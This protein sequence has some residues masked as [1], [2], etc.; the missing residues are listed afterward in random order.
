MTLVKAQLRWGSAAGPR[1][2]ERLHAVF[3]RQTWLNACG[4]LFVMPQF[5]NYSWEIFLSFEESESDS[6]KMCLTSR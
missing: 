6:M 4:A 2:R 5:E 3:T 1:T